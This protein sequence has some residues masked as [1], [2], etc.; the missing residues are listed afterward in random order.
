MLAKLAGTNHPG[1]TDKSYF[2]LKKK[3]DEIKFH[4]V[5]YQLK[6]TPSQ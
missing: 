4:F 1:K 5:I 6:K 3:I 2:D